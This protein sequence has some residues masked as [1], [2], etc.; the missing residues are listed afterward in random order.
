MGWIS[1]IAVYLVIWWLVIFMVLPWGNQPLDAV[2]V[3]RGHA[4]SAP[5]KPHL[6]IKVAATTAIAGIL[7][8]IVYVI[9]DQGW[10]SLRS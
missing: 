8:A 1:G 10:I 2:D 3:A 9:M 4:P 6:A 5:R 7:W